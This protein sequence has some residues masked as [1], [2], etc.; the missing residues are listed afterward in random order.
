MSLDMPEGAEI[1]NFAVHNNV[2]CIWALV[3][4]T[5]HTE[6]RQFKVVGTG[7]DIHPRALR[8]DGLVKVMNQ[9]TVDTL[10]YVGT[11]INYEHYY[12]WHLFE[13]L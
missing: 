4:P 13:V 9:G 5:A 2:P 12:V 1:L 8:K 3:D 11:I 10:D 7:A 6:I